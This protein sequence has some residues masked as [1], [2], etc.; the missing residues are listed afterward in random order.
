MKH[1]QFIF[2]LFFLMVF[3]TTAQKNDTGR[4]IWTAA[5]A[6]EW[7]SKQPWLVGANFLPSTAINEL[8]MWQAETFDTTTISREFGWAAALGMN[9]MRIFLHDLAYKQDPDGF[10]KRMEIVLRIANRYHIKPLFVLFDSCWDPFPHQGK[11]HEPAPF[12]H[13]SGWVQSPGADAL[14]DL[15]QYPRLKKYVVDVV[16][17]FSK[18]KRVLGWDVWNEPDN[19]NNSSYGRFEAYDKVKQVSNLLQK[20][21][22]WTRSANP[23]QPITSGI[24][25]GDWSNADSLKP[26]EKMMVEQSDIISFHNYDSGEEIEKRIQWLQRY[27]RP[28]ICTE[29]MSRGNGSTFEGSMPVA[30]KYKI[31][32]FNW[33]L[34]SGKSQTIFPWDSWSKKYTTQPDLWFHD[35]FYRD[36]KPYKQTEVDFITKITALKTK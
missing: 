9:T 8:E 19:T 1:L 22:I 11:Q 23:S 21:F 31:A 34:V 17:F 20:V 32:I 2:P 26:I 36:G 35:I 33:G 25:A 3:K 4:P 15:T 30:K 5:K 16:G 27:N 6:T 7:Y 29:Y 12:L 24:W 10:K 18:D 13:N 28:I 14:K